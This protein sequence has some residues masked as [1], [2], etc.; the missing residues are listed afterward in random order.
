MNSHK[1]YE[2]L[3]RAAYMKRYVQ[4]S[5]MWEV[6]NPRVIKILTLFIQMIEDDEMFD[7]KQI[8]QIELILKVVVEFWGKKS[9]NLLARDE[10]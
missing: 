2:L 8:D 10:V 9:S 3:E 7:E 6:N 5:D 4:Q 1:K